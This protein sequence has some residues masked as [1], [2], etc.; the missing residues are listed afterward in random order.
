M[1]NEALCFFVKN[2]PERAKTLRFD[3]QKCYARYRVNPSEYFLY[4]FNT[5]KDVT[6]RKSFV[7]DKVKDLVCLKITGH[8]KFAN[9]LAD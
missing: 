9:V 6:Y 2:D 1:L 8:E 4:G 3:I 7:S 5:N